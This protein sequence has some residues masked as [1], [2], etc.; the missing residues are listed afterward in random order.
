MDLLTKKDMKPEEYVLAHS[1]II[2]GMKKIAGE[3]I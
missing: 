3:K 2:F 1:I